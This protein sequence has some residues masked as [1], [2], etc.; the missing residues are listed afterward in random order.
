MDDYRFDFLNE[1]Y[2]EDIMNLQDICIA[3]SDLIFASNEETYKLSFRDKNFCTGVFIEDKLIAFC[4]CTHPAP[5]NKRNL[6]IGVI[7]DNNLDKVGHINT[8]LIHPNY[9]QKGLGKQIINFCV[10]AFSEKSLIVNYVMTTVDAANEP[11]LSMFLKINFT[12]V[13]EKKYHAHEGD[14]GRFVLLRTKDEDE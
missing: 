7:E 2:L 3:N 1:N 5:D 13:N 11:S 4:N 10:N 9:R 6:G 14:L 12:V 8:I